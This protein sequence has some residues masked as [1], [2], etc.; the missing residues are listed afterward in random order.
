VTVREPTNQKAP[1]LRTFSDWLFTLK[2]AIISG[3]VSGILHTQW[4][5]NYFNWTPLAVNVHGADYGFDSR[6][7]TGV[8]TTN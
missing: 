3:T 8:E 7:R 2:Q 6:G 1:F 5:V 4:Q